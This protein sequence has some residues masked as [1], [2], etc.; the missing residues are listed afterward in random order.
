MLRCFQHVATCDKYR[1]I[2]DYDLSRAIRKEVCVS[3]VI[4]SGLASFA[5][6]GPP[7]GLGASDSPSADLPPPSILHRHCALLR[8]L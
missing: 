8:L 2:S 1:E 4:V 5:E 7:A 6:C 3:A